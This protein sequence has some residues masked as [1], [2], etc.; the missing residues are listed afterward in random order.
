MSSKSKCDMCGKEKWNVS[1][2]PS[3]SHLL[4]GGFIGRFENRCPTC[5]REVVDW[6]NK[7]IKENTGHKHEL[8]K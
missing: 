5:E 4:F 2:E 8:T 6:A 3:R 7:L 1:R